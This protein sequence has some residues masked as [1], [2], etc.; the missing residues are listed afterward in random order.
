[1][2]GQM[3]KLVAEIEDLKRRITFLR[4]KK[5]FGSS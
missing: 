5:G 4:N 1:M 3:I 2:D